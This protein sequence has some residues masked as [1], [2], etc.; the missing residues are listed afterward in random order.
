MRMRRGWASTLAVV[1]SSRIAVMQTIFAKVLCARQPRLKARPGGIRQAEP[2]DGR[3][4]RAGRSDGLGELDDELAL[5]LAPVGAVGLAQH[6][7]A[8]LQREV[9]IDVGV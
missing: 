6:P 3:T 7:A 2:S 5:P 4:D 1:A 9:A 8:A